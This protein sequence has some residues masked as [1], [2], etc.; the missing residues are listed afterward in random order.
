MDEAVFSRKDIE[1]HYYRG[2]T[3][4]SKEG[5]L[6]SSSKYYDGF[7]VPMLLAFGFFESWRSIARDLLAFPVFLHVIQ[8]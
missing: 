7:K 5:M 6:A 1:C 2:Y 3:I 8:R 4:L